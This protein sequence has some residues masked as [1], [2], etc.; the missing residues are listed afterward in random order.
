MFIRCAPSTGDVEVDASAYLLN[1]S[2]RVRPDADMVFFNQLTVENGAVRLL[3]A[4]E[5][6]SAACYEVALG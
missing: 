2:A 6:E 5:T 3:F 1:H 4:S